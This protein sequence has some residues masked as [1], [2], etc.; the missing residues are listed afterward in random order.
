MSVAPGVGAGPV[1]ATPQL[2]RE[3]AHYNA[4]CATDPIRRQ[5]EPGIADYAIASPATD[6]TG[7]RREAIRPAL[8]RAAAGSMVCYMTG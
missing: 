1:A 5:W 7:G 2:R 6:R 4:S 3:S 8:N